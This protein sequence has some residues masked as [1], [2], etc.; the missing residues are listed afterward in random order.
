[1][2]DRLEQDKYLTIQLVSFDKPAV[3]IE[4]YYFLEMCTLQATTILSSG[5]PIKSLEIVAY[6]SD[7]KFLDKQTTA[8]FKTVGDFNNF[9]LN[10]PD[11][12][13]HNCNIELEGGLTISSH[14]DGEVTIQFKNETPDQSIVEKI[15]EKYGINKTLISVMKDKSGHYLSIDGKGNIIAEFENF[16]DY[17]ENGRN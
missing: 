4:R 6:T 8:A 16:D 14:D 17:I 13:I 15:F 11:Y 10:N 1:M 12:Y 7:D 9:F 3:Q 2:V 5:R